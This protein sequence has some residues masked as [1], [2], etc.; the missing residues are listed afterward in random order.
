M[1]G[2]RG[3]LIHGTQGGTLT[4]GTAGRQNGKRLHSLNQIN[5]GNVAATLAMENADV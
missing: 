4:F 1:S 2:H 5:E 3:I